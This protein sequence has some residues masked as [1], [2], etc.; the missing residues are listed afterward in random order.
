MYETGNTHDK[1][2]RK[3][4]NAVGDVMGHYHP[5]GDQAIYTPSCAWRRLSR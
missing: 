1:A 5:H 4:A 2:Y 3:C